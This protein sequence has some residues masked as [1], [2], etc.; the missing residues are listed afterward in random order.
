MPAT[1]QKVEE[2]GCRLAIYQGL[3]RVSTLI[4]SITDYE[5]MLEAVLEVARDVLDAEAASLFFPAPDGLRLVIAMTQEGVDRPEL[6]VPLGHGVAGWVWE[7][8][9]PVLIPDAY[10]DSRFFAQADGKTGF[11]TRSI[12]CS[13]LVHEG[14]SMAVLQVL[15]PAHKPAFDEA[16]LE[17]MVGYSSLIATALEKMRRMEARRKEELFQRDLHIASEIQQS[18]LAKAIPDHITSCTIE[19]LNQPA[20]DVGGDFYFATETKTGDLQFAI[21]DVS[22]KGISAALWMT[23]VVS[24]LGFVTR[25]N[26]SPS[27]ALARINSVLAAQSVRGMFVTML[28][29]RLRPATDRLELAS[30]GH[31]NPWLLSTDGP[32]EEW[33][34]PPG[35]PLGILPETTYRTVSRPFTR[36]DT[37]LTFT[38]GLPESR[39][40]SGEAYFG[41]R[42]GEILHSLPA[43]QR[44]SPARHLLAAEETFRGPAPRHDD[45]TILSLCRK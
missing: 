22:G 17:A 20:L 40:P 35:L 31:C 19:A 14:K 12:L 39:G 38:D 44:R 9:E 7:H 36:G 21:G 10:A 37:L 13:P 27:R 8:Q 28:L 32:I 30:A 41:D 33:T 15:N 25:E 3:V 23:Q 26:L 42:L 43:P 1:S 24:A 4:N 2:L 16:D 34:L 5:A 6:L 45:L 18:L 11:R 29:G